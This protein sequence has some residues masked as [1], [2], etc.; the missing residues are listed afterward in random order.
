MENIKV[1]IRLLSPT[2]LSNGEPE[3]LFDDSYIQDK[4]K[5]PV[6]PA[7]RFKGLLRESCL[8]LLEWAGAK[9]KSD[10]INHIFGKQG[11][12]NETTSSKIQVFNG[13]IINRTE[14]VDI[15][16]K[17]N[18]DPDILNAV[19][20]F[21]SLRMAQTQIEENGIAKEG[22]L[23]QFKLLAPKEEASFTFSLIKGDGLNQELIDLIKLA[24]INIRRVGTGRNRGWGK[25][26][27]KLLDSDLPKKIDWD[28]LSVDEPENQ[29]EKESSSII[30]TSQTME[31]NTQFEKIGLKLSALSNLII[32]KWD[33]DENTV[34]TKDHIPGSMLWGALAV[35]YIK[36]FIGRNSNAM[37]DPDFRYLFYGNG[38]TVKP[39]FPYNE[40]EVFNYAP[41]HWVRSKLKPADS[42]RNMYDEWVVSGKP[43]SDLSSF[44]FETGQYRVFE[45]QKTQTF[46]NSRGKDQES[47][48]SGTNKD[49]GIYYYESINKGTVFYTEISID[50]RLKSKLL[51]LFKNKK[52]RV[53]KSK[54]NQFGNVGLEIMTPLPQKE[55]MEESTNSFDLVFESPVILIKENGFSDLSLSNIVK[56]LKIEQGKVTKTNIR[57]ENVQRFQGNLNVL[58]PYFEAIMPGSSIRIEGLNAAEKLNIKKWMTTGIG[59]ETEKGY[60]RFRLDPIKP[61]LKFERKRSTPKTSHL[62]D[63]NQYSGTI[64]A[65]LRFELTKKEAKINGFEKAGNRSNEYKN[66]VYQALGW[67]ASCK[68]GIN[69]DDWNR[70]RDKASKKVQEKFIR[71]HNLLEIY[72]AGD[73]PN[74]S[75]SEIEQLRYI[76]A[77][78]YVERL[79]SNLN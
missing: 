24:L 46:H 34:S 25:V 33:G 70:F 27:V 11:E 62:F 5:L 65:L 6:F 40:Q 44:N 9:K 30:G 55:T 15:I 64:P 23:R 49:A 8:E 13:E 35:E 20:S 16:E 14:W 41:R 45:S 72:K 3:G 12:S 28:K 78:T 67:L 61:N 17:S 42:Y 1:Q 68:G 52:L 38:L 51:H 74:F 63:L 39:A 26:E 54:N 4:Y 59:L 37:D 36:A 22:S 53:G 50:R 29:E 75:T 77:L 71:S 57:F 47:R 56:S 43:I 58:L 2:L 7:K 73:D 76:A 66:G 79:K 32:P 60:G 19:D 18:W 48:L 10:I 31:D 69:E 21:F